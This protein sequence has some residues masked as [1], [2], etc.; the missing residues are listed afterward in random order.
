MKIGQALRAE[1]IKL[2]L[3][4]KQMC[5]GIVSRPFYAK[6]EA[7]KT[8]I[9]AEN[10]FRILFAHQVDINDF[11]RYIY[12]EYNSDENKLNDQFQMKMIQAFNARDIELLEKYSH[13]IVTQSN[14]EVLKLRAIVTVAY[15]KGELDELDDGIKLQIKKQFDEGNKWVSRPESLRLLSNTMPLWSQD[16]LDFW[17]NRLV[18]EISKRTYSELVTERYLQILCN[19]LATCYDRKVYKDSLHKKYIA[20]VNKYI[21]SV[22]DL[23]YHLM[24]YRIN[25]LYLKTLFE[26]DR[27]EATRIL[28]D[29]KKSGYQ[30]VTKAWPRM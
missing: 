11:Y 16:E 19:Y 21:F 22:T 30:T 10:L 20:E 8:G 29:I 5:A 2:G 1:R 9:S 15:F 24:I 23:P 26:N 18:K 6:V 27:K 7:G 12:D 13:E 14:D 25:A 17:I 3:S 28:T 4:Q